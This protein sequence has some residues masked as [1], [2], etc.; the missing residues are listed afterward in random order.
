MIGSASRLSSIRPES[1]E[2]S[3]NGREGVMANFVFRF[4]FCLIFSTK[5]NINHT[6]MFE[7]FFFYNHQSLKKRKS[8]LFIYKDSDQKLFIFAH[9][10]LLMKKVN[11]CINR[12]T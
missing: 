1:Y 3:V 6:V 4:V 9:F 8:S 7:Y 10:V 2:K 11:C 5:I 12:K